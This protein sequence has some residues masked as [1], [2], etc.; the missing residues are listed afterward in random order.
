MKSKA[1]QIADLFNNDRHE[2]ETDTDYLPEICFAHCAR[3]YEFKQSDHT[4]YEKYVFYD[5]S[6]IVIWDNK[7]WAF[8]LNNRDNDYRELE[9]QTRYLTNPWDFDR[10]CC[11]SGCNW[12]LGASY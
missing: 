9:S 1:Q 12:C 6:S 5:N 3:N 10:E 11:A 8:G 2:L 7:E 4:H